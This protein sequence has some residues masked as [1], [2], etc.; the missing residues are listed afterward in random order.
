MMSSEMARI[1]RSRAEADAWRDFRDPDECPWVM[2]EA[3][4][5]RQGARRPLDS[6]TGEAGGFRLPILRHLRFTKEGR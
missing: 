2:D 1:V 6:L 3:A 4:H 5:R